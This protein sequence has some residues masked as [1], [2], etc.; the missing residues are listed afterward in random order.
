MA[1]NRKPKAEKK[2]YIKPALTEVRLV[3]DEAVLATCKQNNGIF[4]ACQGD[5]SC[6]NS[7]QWS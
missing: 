7:Q 6:M 5:L 2:E 4:A 1:D 3:P